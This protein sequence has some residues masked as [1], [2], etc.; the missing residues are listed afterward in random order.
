M[1]STFASPVSIRV[2]SGYVIAIAL[3][4][5]S[6]L[7]PAAE[8]NA[9]MTLSGS[10]VF[11]IGIDALAAGRATRATVLAPRESIVTILQGAESSES[12]PESRLRVDHPA[13][14]IYP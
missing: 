13:V 2:K 9:S 10:R 8:L 4:C 14:L 5:A 7:L 3:W 1:K 11:M 12:Y 6:L